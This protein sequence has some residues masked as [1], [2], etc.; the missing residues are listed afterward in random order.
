MGID[1]R[2]LGFTEDFAGINFREFSLT[3]DFAVINFF[4]REYALQRFYVNIFNVCL[5]EYFSSTTV[6]GFE[7]NFSKIETFYINK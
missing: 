2:E 1:F 3:K 5:Q 6:C 7:D 4:L